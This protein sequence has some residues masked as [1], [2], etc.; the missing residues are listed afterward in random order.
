M[1]SIKFKKELIAPCGMNCNICS[2]F[3]ADENTLKEKGV[4]MPYCKG[5]RPREK[6][7]AF[8]KKGCPLLPDNKVEYCYQCPNFP[9]ENLK[10]LDKKYQ[11]RFK[12][13]MIANLK[14]IKENGV[15]KFLQ[16]DQKKWQCPKCKAVI[17]C[18]NGLCF[19]CQ[20]NKL[21]TKKNKYQWSDKK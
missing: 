3:L 6:Q 18:H 17:C 4:K 13:S 10:K 20:L 1:K 8:L 2:A 21:K 12:M 16:K 19:N 7:C 11:E 5:C 14:Y 9:C 15:E